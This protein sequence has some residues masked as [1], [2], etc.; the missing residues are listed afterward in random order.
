[1]LLLTFAF[2]QRKITICFVS[3]KWSCFCPHWDSWLALGFIS[4]HYPT[5][6]LNN[7]FKRKQKNLRIWAYNSRLRDTAV[8]CHTGSLTVAVRSWNLMT[9]MKPES[10]TLCSQ[11]LW[12]LCYGL[13]KCCSKLN[14]IYY[15]KSLEVSLWS[16]N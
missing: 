9:Y 13:R 14:T 16:L 5:S 1:M 4:L 2:S 7:L 11:L 6:I 8:S 15:W 3:W 12:W 10:Y